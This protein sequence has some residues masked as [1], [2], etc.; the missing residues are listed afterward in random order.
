MSERVCKRERERERESV[1]VCVSEW[2]EGEGG[3]VK[4]C[5]VDKAD[6]N[7]HL[8]LPYLYRLL[9]ILQHLHLN[10]QIIYLYIYTYTCT[11]HTQRDACIDMDRH[12]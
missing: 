6:G 5:K 8:R 9:C 12:K 3:H 7:I 4:K 1:C 11:I 10:S 2:E